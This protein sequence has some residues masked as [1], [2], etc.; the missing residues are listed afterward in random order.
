[1]LV[2]IVAGGLLFKERA[3]NLDVRQLTC[4]CYVLATDTLQETWR[5][6]RRQGRHLW[7]TQEADLLQVTGDGVGVDA[8]G[9]GTGGNGCCRLEQVLEAL[10]LCG[11]DRLN[12]YPGSVVVPWPL[13][14]ELAEV[15]QSNELRQS[16]K[17]V[18]SRPVSHRVEAHLDQLLLQVGV[19]EILDLVVSPPR[20]VF[21][22][23]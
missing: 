10:E 21:R 20:E 16:S 13:L 15:G 22:N 8:A 2:G 23:S 18:G 4:S 6:Q 5:R 12:L 7:R 17:E 19:P 3:R 14:H 11:L 9:A 1:M